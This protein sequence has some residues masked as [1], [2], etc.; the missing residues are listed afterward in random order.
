MV[1]EFL[2][3][4]TYIMQSFAVPG[5]IEHG[6]MQNNPAAVSCSVRTPGVKRILCHAVEVL[7]FG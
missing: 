6:V 3:V 1:H 2:W 7:Q 4:R 5:M